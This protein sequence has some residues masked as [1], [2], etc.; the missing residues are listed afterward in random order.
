MAGLQMD[1]SFNTEKKIHMCVCIHLYVCVY[2]YSHVSIKAPQIESS[3]FKILLLFSLL[4]SLIP[5][6]VIL[7]VVHLET[8]AI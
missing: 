7:S 2:I 5:F 4:C 8:I 1:K 6:K 3:C